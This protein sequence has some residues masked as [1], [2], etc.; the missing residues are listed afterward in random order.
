MSLPNFASLAIIVVALLHVAFFVLE[1]FF[2]TKPLGRR[3][4]GMSSE[5]AAG[6]ASLAFNQG[7]YNAFLAAGL[8]WGLFAHECNVAI[9]TFFLTCVLIAGIV[10]G[11]T[12]KRSILFIQGLPAAIALLLVLF[13]HR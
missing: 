7:L 11:I 3:V 1:S 13:G 8:V 6:S 4:F 9:E 5:L 10:G 2:W 12:A